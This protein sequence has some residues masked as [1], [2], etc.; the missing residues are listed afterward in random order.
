MEISLII[1]LFILNAILKIYLI[2][3]IIKK[4][5]QKK[6]KIYA[7]TYSI[8]FSAWIVNIIAFKY[9]TSAEIGLIFSAFLSLAIDLGILQWFRAIWEKPE[10]MNDIDYG[11]TSIQ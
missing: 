2:Y 4:I 10:D 3:F 8:V 1:E 7:F 5:K 6:T 9:C 11:D